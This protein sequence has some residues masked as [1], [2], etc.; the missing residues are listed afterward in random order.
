MRYVDD[1]FKVWMK[2]ITDNILPHL[3]SQDVHIS[4]TVER[5]ENIQHIPTIY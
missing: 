1:I 3:N 4:F 5:D 2:N